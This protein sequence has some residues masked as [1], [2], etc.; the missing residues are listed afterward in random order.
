MGQML[1]TMCL[2]VFIDTDRQGRE[3]RVHVDKLYVRTWLG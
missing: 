2:A 1:C 3:A